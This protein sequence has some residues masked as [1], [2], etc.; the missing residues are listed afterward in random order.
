[1]LVLALDFAIHRLP[2]FSID[3]AVAIIFVI[4]WAILLS[5]GLCALRAEPE[6]SA[7]LRVGGFGVAFA[8]LWHTGFALNYLFG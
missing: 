2:E 4:P 1:M 3:S 8:L 7:L 6:A 5:A